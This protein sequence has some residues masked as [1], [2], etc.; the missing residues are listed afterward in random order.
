MGLIKSGTTDEA[1]EIGVNF[2]NF[3]NLNGTTVQEVLNYIDTELSSITAC[4]TSN[5]LER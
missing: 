2:T 1:D 4:P 3:T 5:W